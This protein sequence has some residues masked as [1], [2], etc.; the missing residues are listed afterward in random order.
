MNMRLLSLI[1]MAV[2][3]NRPLGECIA[4]PGDCLQRSATFTDLFC[5]CSLTLASELG[6]KVVKEEGTEQPKN[7]HFESRFDMAYKMATGPE[8]PQEGS[9]AASTISDHLSL[10]FARFFQS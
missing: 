9:R 2:H 4:F 7:G 10:E 8:E 6:R 1:Q 3:V 5:S